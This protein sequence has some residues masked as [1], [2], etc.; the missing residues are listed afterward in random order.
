[1]GY[2]SVADITGRFIFIRLAVVVSQIAKSAEI[3]TKFDLTAVQGHPRSSIFN[4]SLCV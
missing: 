4:G 3:R 1:M 2:N